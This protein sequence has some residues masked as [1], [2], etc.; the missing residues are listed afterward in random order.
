VKNLIEPNEQSGDYSAISLN[1]A[2]P[3]FQSVAKAELK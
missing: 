1:G 2:D 3:A